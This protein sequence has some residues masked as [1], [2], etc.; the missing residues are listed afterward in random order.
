M[1][2]RMGT[3][4]LMETGAIQRLFCSIKIKLSILISAFAFA[5]SIVVGGL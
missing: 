5:K 4:L 1:L 3:G 2:T